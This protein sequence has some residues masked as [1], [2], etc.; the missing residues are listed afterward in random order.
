MVDTLDIH[1]VLRTTAA[2]ETTWLAV[3]PSES[4]G[5][6]YGDPGELN[7][8]VA[9]L[10]VPLPRYSRRRRSLSRQPRRVENSIHAAKIVAVFSGE[11]LRRT[12]VPHG[13][14]EQPAPP[15]G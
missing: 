14:A 5:P 1:F 7:S 4:E 10:A 8:P 15:N 3:V 13:P 9:L 11:S 6:F 12:G 2:V